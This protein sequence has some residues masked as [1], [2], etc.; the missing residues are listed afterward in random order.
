ME[1][2]ATLKF[3]R[4]SPRKARLVV[5]V[6]RGKQVDDALALLRFMPQHAAHDVAK[7][8]ASAKANAENNLELAAETLYIK[9]IQA[10]DGPRLKRLRAA[11]R[12]RA[13]R[14]IKRMCHISVVVEDR[15]EAKTASG[16]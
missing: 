6:V 3:V 14:I 9:E 11:P 15:E 12:G 8:I 10:V 4:S 7:V 13:N 2:R 1:A 16:T 5:D